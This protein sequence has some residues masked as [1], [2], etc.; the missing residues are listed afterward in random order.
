MGDILKEVLCKPNR[1]RE[2]G[3][4]EVCRT[5]DH[6]P[7]QGGVGCPVSLEHRGWIGG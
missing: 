4:V 2:K 1:I 6:G 7:E 3:S 5:R